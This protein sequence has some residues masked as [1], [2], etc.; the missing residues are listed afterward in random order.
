[1]PAVLIGAVVVA[2]GAVA[3][4]AIPRTRP[5]AGEVGIIEA[6]AAQ[7]TPRQGGAAP[8]PVYVTIDD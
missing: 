4:Y 5:V 1:M 3:A 6:E 8:I 2:V 7:A